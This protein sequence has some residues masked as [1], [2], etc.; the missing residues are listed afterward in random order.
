MGKFANL[1]G[2]QDLQGRP[3]K[4]ALTIS[5]APARSVDSRFA[6]EVLDD[7]LERASYFQPQFSG[8]PNSAPRTCGAFELADRLIS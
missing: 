1:I 4:S 6:Y 8:S 7:V 3:M 2:R 5:R